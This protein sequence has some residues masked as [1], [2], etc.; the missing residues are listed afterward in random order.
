MQSPVSALP[1]QS[2]SFSVS[3]LEAWAPDVTTA[4]DWR[5]WSSGTRKIGLQGEPAL[6]QMPPLL[7]RH[8]GRLGRFACEVAYRAL[9]VDTGI[10][11]V[12]SSR[13]GEASRSVEL[14]T[15]LVSGDELSPTSFGL[16]VH[17]AITGLLGIARRDR[18]N[19]ITLAACD[20]S[21]EHGLL[22][23]C[24][25]LAD[26][27]DEVLVI[28]AD[29]PLP[30]IYSVFDD[31]DPVAFAW[32]V[33]ITPPANAPVSLHWETTNAA[34]ARGAEIHAALTALRFLQGNDRKME[35]VSASHSWRWE[36]DA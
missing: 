20:E 11:I 25:L 16:S 13:Y 14:L 2:V 26:G 24:S 19:C 29:V 35:H 6:Q 3:Q 4:D 31:T 30:P 8:A 27:A 17:N 33:R 1:A 9:A 5:A 23:A 18:S 21:A 28:V 7:R 36:R 34:P 22:E 32:A 15:S 12:F 10:P